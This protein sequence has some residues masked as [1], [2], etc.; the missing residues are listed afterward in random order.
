MQ[1]TRQITISV[2][3][4]EKLIQ[5]A[6]GKSQSQSHL[7]KQQFLCWNCFRKYNVVPR[8]EDE[9]ESTKQVSCFFLFLFAKE[10][11]I[12]WILAWISLSAAKERNL[13][14]IKWIPWELNSR[15]KS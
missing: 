2:K 13:D 8:I 15:V 4:R 7:L 9:V 6:N 11:G 10:N 14:G 1:I 5:Y 3:S 12:K